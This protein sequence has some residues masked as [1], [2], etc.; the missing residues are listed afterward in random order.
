MRPMNDWR[1]VRL[2][3]TALVSV[4]LLGWIGFIILGFGVLDA[5]YQTVTTISTVGFREVN[6]FGPA[7][8]IFTIALVIVGVGTALYTLTTVLE[9]LLEGRL[10]DLYGRRRMERN[11]EKFTDHVIVCG[12][13]R[14]G[15]ALASL[16]SG[17]GTTVVM[18]DID[19]QRLADTGLPFV[20][21]DATVDETLTRAG[22][23]RC[24]SLV[25]ALDTDA[26]NLFVT[27]SARAVRPDLFI[28]ARTRRDDNTEK[29]LRA[30]ADR[31]V[32]PQSIGGARMAAFIMQPN[33]A[34]FLDVVMHDGSLEFR[35]EEVPVPETSA[36]IGQSLK[37]LDI[38]ARTGALVLALRNRDG[39]FT[40]NP[41][42]D[43]IVAADQVL[44]AVGTVDQLH[45]L[46]AAVAAP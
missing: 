13:G 14:A 8:K 42:V 15:K 21:G 30:G 3:V 10:R 6:E 29:L 24:R 39:S 12:C 44:I 11:I 4:T 19:E 45:Q 18:V 43:T 2:A 38:R 5:L 25:A 7:E 46:E 1:R 41:Q 33:V 40:S 37:D 35:L 36:A 28:V 22:L 17:S 26:A 27:L 20:V 9:A 31:V 32:N 23:A 34:E 16:V